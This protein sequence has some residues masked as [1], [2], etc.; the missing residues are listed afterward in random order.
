VIVIQINPH[1]TSVKNASKIRFH[2]EECRLMGCY[3]VWHNSVFLRSVRQ[4]LV[5]ANVVPNS[6]ILVTLIMEA[7]DSS[8][9]SVLT[10]VTRR[11]IPEDDILHSHCH[12]N[13]KSYIVF[14]VFY[15]LPVIIS[16]VSPL[17]LVR[18]P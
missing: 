4:L 11:H 16:M 6:P 18:E 5:T 7:L 9:T 3:A 14:M 2:G 15:D 17:E 12:E 13:L 10:R 1:H 8:E